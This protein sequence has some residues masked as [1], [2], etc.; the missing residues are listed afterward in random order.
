MR[1]HDIVVLLKGIC[2]ENSWMNKDL[3]S[4]LFISNSEISESLNRSKIAGLIFHTK[5]K[6]LEM[7]CS[8]S[9]KMDFRTYFLRKRVLYQKASQLHIAHRY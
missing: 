2:L 3:A 4:A 6:F 5:R 7:H 9:L 8:I 1:P